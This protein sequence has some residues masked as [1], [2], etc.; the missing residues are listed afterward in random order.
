MGRRHG[1]IRI[2]SLPHELADQSGLDLLVRR[3]IDRGL[4]YRAGRGESP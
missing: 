1:Q 4:V 3:L 2:S